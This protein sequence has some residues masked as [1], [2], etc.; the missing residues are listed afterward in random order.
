MSATAAFAGGMLVPWLVRRNVFHPALGAVAVA[1]AIAIPGTSSVGVGRLLAAVAAVILVGLAVSFEAIR[2]DRSV[3]QRVATKLGD[4]SYAL[5]LCHMP[6][7]LF[8]YRYLPL[9][10]GAAW[11]VAVCGAVALSVPLGKLDLKLYAWLRKRTDRSTPERVG[12]WAWIYVG[13][14][15]V[16]AVI[17]LFKK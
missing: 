2:S 5:Y 17:F 8:V 11:A 15:A 9:T 16:V 14:Y 6:M 13:V 4:W 10:G 1:A 12:R 3:A 7:V